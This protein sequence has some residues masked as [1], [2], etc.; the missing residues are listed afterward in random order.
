MVDGL[1]DAKFANVKLSNIAL[2][3]DVVTCDFRVDATTESLSLRN[4]DMNELG[5]Y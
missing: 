2:P 3:A 5:F 1:A 4:R